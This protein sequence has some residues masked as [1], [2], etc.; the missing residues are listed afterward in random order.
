MHERERDWEEG[1]SD[2]HG[3]R[4]GKE[5]EGPLI[6][7]LI[8]AGSDIN[9]VIDPFFALHKFSRVTRSGHNS[10]SFRVLGTHTTHYLA[11]FWLRKIQMEKDKE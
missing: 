4:R 9:N 1:Y 3:R 11:N 8:R 6:A 5:R 2:L 7:F 10:T